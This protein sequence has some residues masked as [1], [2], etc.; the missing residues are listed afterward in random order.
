MLFDEDL[1]ATLDAA[2][3]VDGG[4][5]Y[6]QLLQANLPIFTDIYRT[7]RG[8]KGMPRVNISSIGDHC[9]RRIWYRYRAVKDEKFSGRLLRLFNRGHMEE[10]RIV[11]MLEAAG[12]SVTHNDINN[13]KFRADLISGVA[14]G[15]AEN[16]PGYSGKV[17][18]EFKTMS[19]AS[20]EKWKK[21]GTLLYSKDYFVQVQFYLAA[22]RLNKCL[23]IAVC[24]DNDDF[25]IE[26]IERQDEIVEQ[27]Y[28][29]AERIA[30]VKEPPPRINDSPLW[31]QCKMCSFHGICHGG[32]PVE[33]NCRT[34][35][36]CHNEIGW[37]CHVSAYEPVE[38]SEAEQ[39]EG[40][41][42][43]SHIPALNITE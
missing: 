43:H 7:R 21:E 34:C 37:H 41:N 4:E 39:R 10:A 24:K 26:V 11:S 14:D 29:R 16:V 8:D 17:L 32:Q 2:V 33:K 1:K 38:L 30:G 23:F 12:I 19:K 22:F 18:L 42:L 40:C 15:I 20:F 13:L 3:E 6:R 25:E 27:Y 35:E 5:R 31:W 28:E 36:H 9:A